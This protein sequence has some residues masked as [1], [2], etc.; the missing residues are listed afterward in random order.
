MRIPTPKADGAPGS[1]MRT[2]VAPGDVALTFDDGPDPVGT[3]AVLDALALRGAV[4]TFF[5]QGRSVDLHPGLIRSIVEAGH[6]VGL[7]C[8]DHT[9][10][11][12]MTPG[13]IRADID[14]GL[15]A[16]ARLEIR[17][18]AWRTPWGDTSDATGAVAE[19]FG[20]EL[21]GWSRDTHDWRGD[22]SEQMLEVLAQAGIKAGDVILMHDGLGPGARREDCLQTV[23]LADALLALIE[24]EG[25]R[26][27]TLSEALCRSR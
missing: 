21:W 2:A 3:E 23:R 26:L 27:T 15:A 20:L 11:S 25:L 19:E 14:A 1:A 13:E 10:H 24:E 7:H 18:T 6:E 4:A 22:T 16:L 17:P 12:A 8:F 9:R 5:V